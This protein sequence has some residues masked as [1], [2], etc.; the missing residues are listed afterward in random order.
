MSENPLLVLIEK[1]LEKNAE[2]QINLDSQAA[3]KNLAEQI[4]GSLLGK[5]YIVSYR[6]QETFE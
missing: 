3:R 6:T 1:V 2:K 5:Y 4:V